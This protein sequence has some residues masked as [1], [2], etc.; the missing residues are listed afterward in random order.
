MAH[1]AIETCLREAAF[2]I[3]VPRAYRNDDAITAVLN[4]VFRPRT[5]ERRAT[6]SDNPALNREIDLLVDAALKDDI[7]KPDQATT[8]A[9]KPTPEPRPEPGHI[10]PGTD[11]LHP[12][13]GADA[14][15][16]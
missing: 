7:T 9:S 12:A 13:T 8:P 1:A 10:T 6:G 2:S 15:V 4:L 5:P 11:A 3:E 14:S 16:P